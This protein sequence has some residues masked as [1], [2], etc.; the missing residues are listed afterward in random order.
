[1]VTLHGKTQKRKKNYDNSTNQCHVI[2][3]NLYRDN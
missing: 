1:M 3:N 2:Q